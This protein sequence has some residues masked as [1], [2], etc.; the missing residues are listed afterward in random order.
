[1]SVGEKVALVVNDDPIQIEMVTV[2]L[3]REGIR[4]ITFLNAEK[5]LEELENVGEVDLVVV[6]LHMPRIDGWSFCWLLRS[7]EFPAFNEVPVLIT[8][9]TFSGLEVEAVTADL[10]A[11]AFLSV[12]FSA[13]IF[14][15][16]VTDLLSGKHPQAEHKVLIVEDDESVRESLSKTF[17]L[18]GYQVRTAETAGD[19]I[20][21]LAG[22]PPDVLVL[23]YH[24]P[25]RLGSVLLEEVRESS[26]PTLVLL[27]TGDHDPD[28]SIKMLKAGA[29][30]YIRKPF[31]PSYL[32][33]LVHK[34]ER[35]RSLLRV[36]D[37]LERRNRAL[38]A[39]ESRYR[40]LF[41]T[42]LEMIFVI[43]ETGAI[44]QANE[45]SEDMLQATA[46]E[47]NAKRLQDLV[48][49]GSQGNL[50]KALAEARELGSG[51]FETSFLTR[52]GDVLNVELSAR[53]MSLDGSPTLLVVGRDITE[54]KE[55][56]AER[57]RLRSRMQ[58]AQ[59]LESLG[60]MAGGMAH[61][62]NNLLVGIMG[63]AGLAMMELTPDHA[64]WDSIVEI[65]LAASQAA[66][67][68]RQ[69]LTYAGAC[70]FSTQELDLSKILKE[71]GQLMAPGVSKKATLNFELASE[72]PNVQ[73]DTS[74]LRQVVMNL[75][76]NASEALEGKPG[77]I[78][79]RTGLVEAD[80]SY[81]TGG[82]LG[83]ER[84][85]GDYVFLEVEDDGCGMDVT[86]RD[87]IFDPFFTTKF[88]GRGLGLAAVLGIVRGHNGDIQVE[89][90][91]NRGT[92]FRVLFPASEAPAMEFSEPEHHDEQEERVQPTILVIDDEETVRK[93]ARSA[94]EREGFHVV[95]AQ[96]G[97]E[98][99]EILQER[100][101]EIDGVLL[102]LSMPKMDGEEVLGAIRE[103]DT[104]MPV[105]LSSGYMDDA[106]EQRLRQ[107]G[108][109][110]FLPK[111]YA[112]M[113]LVESL[114]LAIAFGSRMARS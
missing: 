26:Y 34:L 62:F 48:P 81:L 97:S 16:Y 100:R 77:T 40:A 17:R 113:E 45:A 99:V 12:P 68:T 20:R 71:M 37:I 89:S 51:V 11:N 64:A 54:R 52:D 80:R 14:R 8:S 24:L 6:D 1:M 4:P 67:L 85:V 28:L 50:L 73:G 5:A 70:S 56:E 60:V 46:A 7:P 108:F 33:D 104:E 106:A 10:G 44:L 13:E 112:P 78:T 63:N 35:Q 93:V 32:M 58:H 55:E 53:S 72:L 101:A 65:E 109:T 107:V 18:Q 30:G 95:S 49:F 87:R 98:A 3:E 91:P 59:K 79:I 86:T 76:M 94:L 42:I 105:I 84:P 25:D 27:I 47:L 38:R 82:M 23:D 103:M 69:I 9:A 21:Q 88:T 15:R 36:E 57:A 39:S 29:H 31:E 19:G 111:P 43:D 61:D 110:G 74:Q 90:V 96:D 22:T 75:V 83:P 102:D 66:E 2:L 114:R 92:L 41:S